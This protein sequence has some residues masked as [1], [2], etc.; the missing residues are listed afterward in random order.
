M[1]EGR[2]RLEWEWASS[3]M[4][5]ISNGLARLTSAWD[6]V[7]RTMQEPR[8]FN[9]YLQDEGEARTMP[10]VYEV[11]ADSYEIIE[12]EAAKQDGEQSQY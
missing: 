6:G 3:L 4:A 1:A 5:I 8:D 2:E 10:D 7:R 9:P 11:N 12:R